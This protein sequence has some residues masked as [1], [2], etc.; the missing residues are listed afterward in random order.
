[1]IFL[2]LYSGFAWVQV[3]KS[4]LWMF[5]FI[6]FSAFCILISISRTSVGVA[7]IYASFLVTL[8]F[9]QVRRLGF[10]LAVAG[11]F[12]IIGLLIFERASGLQITD[13]LA[14][15]WKNR[16][17]SGSLQGEFEAAMNH[18]AHIFDPEW[19]HVSRQDPFIGEGFG[20]F[21]VTSNSGFR[22]GHNLLLTEL[23]ENGWLATALLEAIWKFP[24]PAPTNWLCCATSRHS[25]SKM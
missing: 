8:K 10:S 22:D 16:M 3:R 7:A 24:N 23:Y 18:R 25:S 4:F 19:Q 6:G 5:L 13:Q 1:M 17:G 20:N 12:L 14:V 11:C 9:H 2:T 21:H 15:N